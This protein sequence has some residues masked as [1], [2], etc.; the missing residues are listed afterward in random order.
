MHGYEMIQQLDERT[1][2]IWRPSPGSVYPTLQMLEDEGLI[3]SYPV[4]GRKLFTSPT[5]GRGGRQRPPRTRRGPRSPTRPSPRP[6]T[7][8]RRRFGLM[9]ALREVGAQGTDDQRAKA[10]EVLADTSRKLY[11]ILAEED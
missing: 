4:E 8:A 9:N 6:T 10:L 5:R 3:A 2:G 1:G 7:C 11:A